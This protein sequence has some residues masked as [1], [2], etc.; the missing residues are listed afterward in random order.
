M[1]HRFLE[2]TPAEFFRDEL[3]RAMAHQKVS[4]STFTEFYL[5]NLLAGSMR[6]HDVATDDPG[7]ADLPLAEL[8][9]RAIAAPRN[10]RARL[11]RA[12]GDTALFVSGFFADSL[13]RRRAEARYYSSFGSFAYGHLS[14]RDQ[15]LG[16]GPEVYGELAR[17]FHEFADVLT[18]VAD[19]THATASDSVP[20]LYERWLRTGSGA[21]AE[22]LL[23]LGVMPMKP[24][25]PTQH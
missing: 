10:D 15:L 20:Q 13:A 16:F 22:R 21:A 24:Q 9:A 6:S 1:G 18:E 17:R 4:A 8:Y 12:L 11:L 25:R 23:E 19:H 7:A 5:V 14:R 2:K 3:I